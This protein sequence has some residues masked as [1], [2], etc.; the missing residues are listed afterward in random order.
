MGVSI[1]RKEASKVTSHHV[2]QADFKI[3]H[4]LLNLDKF[5]FDANLVHQKQGFIFKFGGERDKYENSAKI[6]TILSE[7]I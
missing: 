1:K 2:T 6:F 4:T 7:F 5:D 3:T